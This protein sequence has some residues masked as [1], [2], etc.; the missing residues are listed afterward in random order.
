M[1]HLPKHLTE[2]WRY[3]AV[4]ITTW[5]DAS[6]SRGAFQRELWFAAQNLVGDVGSADADLTVFDFEGGAG[7][8]E[9]VVRARRGE[10]G[11]ARAALACIDA[12]GGDPVGVRVR[13]VSG[14][15]RA[16]EER[17]LGRAAGATGQRHVA[18]D[19]AD[20][21]AHVRDD[22]LDVSLPDGYVGAA[23]LDFE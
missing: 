22:S 21:P 4:E 3:L 1:K 12:V 18:F 7:E 20:R 2:R 16:C 19:G 6:I 23:E 13:G 17:Y 8:Y 5:P 15:V 14:T 10:V 11:P 9:T